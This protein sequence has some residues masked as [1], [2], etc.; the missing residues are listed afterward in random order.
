MRDHL[1]RIARHHPSV[2]AVRGRGLMQGLVLQSMSPPP[3]ATAAIL[4]DKAFRGGL[5]I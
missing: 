2:T 5:L 3:G 1:E 4:A